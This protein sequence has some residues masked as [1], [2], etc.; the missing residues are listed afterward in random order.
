MKIQYNN[1]Y[2]HFVFSTLDRQRVIT[3]IHH[4]RSGHI[5]KIRFRSD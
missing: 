3:E 4:V 2:T 5:K 1:L